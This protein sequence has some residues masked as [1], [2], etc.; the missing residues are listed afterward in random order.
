MLESGKKFKVVEMGPPLK[1]SIDGIT[2]PAKVFNAAAQGSLRL[3]I[4]KSQ[5]VDLLGQGEN[6]T[7]EKI[8]GAGRRKS[9]RVKKRHASRRAKKHTRRSRY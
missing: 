2:V 5:N 6:V 4:E 9:R 8:V 7:Y 3:S 1:I